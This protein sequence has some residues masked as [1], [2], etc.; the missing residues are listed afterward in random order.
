MKRF[1][2]Y[3]IYRLYDKAL[4]KPSF[5]P[6]VDTITPLAILHMLMFFV[7]TEVFCTFV[8]HAASPILE[9]MGLL[10]IFVIVDLWGH[11]ILFYDKNKWNSIMEEFKDESPAERRKGGW[12]VVGYLVGGSLLC[13]LVFTFIVFMGIELHL[14]P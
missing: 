4:K 7:V 3:I 10:I 1:Y 8:L 2:R 11:Y 9:H 13:F 14:R 12:C 5:T 6:V